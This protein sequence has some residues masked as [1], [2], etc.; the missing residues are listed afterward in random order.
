M[1]SP[2]DD[3]TALLRRWGQGD[4]GALDELMPL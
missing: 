4:R 2:R 3:V 1:P